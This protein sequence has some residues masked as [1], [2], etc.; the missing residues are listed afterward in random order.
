MGKFM[1]AKKNNS[2]ARVAS[3]I[4]DNAEFKPKISNNK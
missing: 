1:P 2:K 3:L 4:L